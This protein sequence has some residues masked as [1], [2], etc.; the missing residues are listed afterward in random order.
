MKVWF[1]LWRHKTR[2]IYSW[3]IFAE[4]IKMLKR[5]S[6]YQVSRFARRGLRLTVIILG[7]KGC[8]RYTPLFI[9]K[10]FHSYCTTFL[11]FGTSSP[12]KYLAF[13]ST[14]RPSSRQVE[15]YSN[16]TKCNRVLDLK[17]TLCLFACLSISFFSDGLT[18]NFYPIYCHD[19]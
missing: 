11:F 19:S 17:P 9:Q 15:P 10:L 16:K 2:F 14:K 13:S 3:I 4:K 7:M 6:Y 12:K 18:R 5:T 1:N 8:N